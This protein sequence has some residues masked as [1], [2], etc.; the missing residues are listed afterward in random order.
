MVD[1]LRAHRDEPDTWSISRYVNEIQPEDI[2]FIWLSNEKG[3]GNRGIYAMAKVTGLPVLHRHFEWEDP[4]WIDKKEQRRLLALSRLELR[5]IK[6]IISKPL[7]VN[8][9]KTASLKDLDILR[10]AQRSI[11][12][13]TREEGDKIKRMIELR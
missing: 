13:L 9:L 3:K 8:D 7:L 12:K 11:Y 1:Y 4:Y 5:Y 6:L 2:A 10:M